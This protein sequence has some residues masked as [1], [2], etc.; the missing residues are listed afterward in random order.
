M[1]NCI[2]ENT[3]DFLN[4]FYVSIYIANNVY[5]CIDINNVLIYELTIK[6]YGE[7]RRYFYAKA[8]YTVVLYSIRRDLKYRSL[9]F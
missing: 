2:N 7:S 1:K 3:T 9:Q 8:F 5:S 6:T 4:N